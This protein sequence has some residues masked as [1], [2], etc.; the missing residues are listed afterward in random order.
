[1]K[2][3]I[4]K[5]TKK[6]LFAVLD[7]NYEPQENEIVIDELYNLEWNEN[8]YFNEETREFIIKPVEQEEIIT[9]VL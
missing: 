7:D 6:V 9:V 4:E 3:V 8:I 5:S 1:M 2:T